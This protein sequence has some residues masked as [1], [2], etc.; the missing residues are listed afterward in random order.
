MKRL[1][2][3]AATRLALLGLVA[4]LVFGNC[5]QNV[6]RVL[7]PGTTPQQVAQLK[8]LNDSVSAQYQA[9]YRRP[10]GAAGPTSQQ[11]QDSAQ[12]ARRRLLSPTQFRRLQLARRPGMMP[13]RYPPRPPRGYR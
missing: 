1:G 5:A 3:P 8:R 6:Y 9:A 13:L 12:A 10:A 2:T 7:G 11:I 4:L